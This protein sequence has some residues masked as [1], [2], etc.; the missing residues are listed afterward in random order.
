MI[1]GVIFI[2][3]FPRKN[4]I[5]SGETFVREIFERCT[6]FY[7][8]KESAKYLFEEL[9]YQTRRYSNYPM[10]IYAVEKDLDELWVNTFDSIKYY[11]LKDGDE[12]KNMEPCIGVIGNPKYFG[13]LETATLGILAQQSAVATSVNKVVKKLKDNQKLFFFPARFRDFSSQISDGYA[14]NIGGA[15]YMSTDAN[16]G[17]FDGEGSGTIPHL[18]IAAYKGNTSQAAAKFDEYID[19]SINRIVLVDWDNDCIKTTL[20]TIWV[21]LRKNI[22]NLDSDD[23]NINDL[24]YLIKSIKDCKY[25]SDVIG[26]GKG[27]IY[28]VRFDTS[29]TNIDECVSK[30]HVNNGVCPELIFTARKVFDEVGLKDLKKMVS[31]GFN[32]EKI[33]LFQSLNVPVDMYGI[34]SSIV[35]NF[36]CDFTADAVMLDEKPN[37]KVGRQMGDWSRMYK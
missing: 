30:S 26:S 7:S 14:A 32:N 11:S 17:Y 35:N 22:Y 29:G 16:Y 19:P 21:F 10:H 20:Q 6:G 12:V 34:G 28:G 23:I 9:C 8:D 31:G 2:Q 4:V 36:H 18:L 37:A 33:D 3:Y 15:D 25:T 1:L 5:L 27:K 13:H 24:S